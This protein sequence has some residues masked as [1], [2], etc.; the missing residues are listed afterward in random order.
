VKARGR[1]SG[2]TAGE[3]QMATTCP[4]RDA[5]R[6]PLS[7]AAAARR[8][9]W[10]CERAKQHRKKQPRALYICPSASG[11]VQR[12]DGDATEARKKWHLHSRSPYNMAPL[13]I[14]NCMGRISSAH[15]TE[16]ARSSHGAKDP[17]PAG[18]ATPLACLAGAARPGHDDNDPPTALARPLTIWRSPPPSTTTTNTH[19]P[20]ARAPRRPNKRWC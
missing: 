9:S 2:H 1:G 18:G 13:L 10:R 11:S 12:S 5:P 6:W 19:G 15:L 3:G 7:R 16:R 4:R 17:V 14:C 20:P 8:A